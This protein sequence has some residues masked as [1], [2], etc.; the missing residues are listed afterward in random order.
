MCVILNGLNTTNR[1]SCLPLTLFTCGAQYDWRMGIAQKASQSR[2]WMSIPAM[3]IQTVRGVDEL[4]KAMVPQW[5]FF[6]TWT[7]RRPQNG[8]CGKCTKMF[9]SEKTHTHTNYI[10]M[11]VYIYIILYII[12]YIYIYTRI[13]TLGGSRHDETWWRRLSNLPLQSNVHC[14]IFFVKVY[15]WLVVST[16]LKN[17]SQLGWLF[18]TYGKR[19]KCSKQPTK[20]GNVW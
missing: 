6:C 4:M 14:S 7:L 10:H 8:K 18:P 19:K 5:C 15:I 12:I 20:Y 3:V 2:W 17:I 16:L 11:Y 9:G 13:H 1:N